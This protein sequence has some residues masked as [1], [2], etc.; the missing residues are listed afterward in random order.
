FGS[1][2]VRYPGRVRARVELIKRTID[3]AGSLTGLAFT[4]PLYLPIALAIKL[5][6]PGPVFFVQRRAGRLVDEEGKPPRWDE[7]KMIKFRTMRVDAERG[8]GA[9]VATKDDPRVT[10]VGRFL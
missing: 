7:F 9:V 4:L 6:S 3:I 2:V 1:G 5:D 10:R 8:T